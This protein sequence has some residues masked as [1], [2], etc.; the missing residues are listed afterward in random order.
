LIAAAVCG[1]G[2]GAWL[3]LRSRPPVYRTGEDHPEITRTLEREIPPE[4]PEPRFTEVG[5]EAGL[6]DYVPFR[7]E[8][9]SQLPEDMGPGAAWGDYDDD[10]DDDLFLVSAGG[11]LGAPPAARAPS[12]L[13]ENRGDGTF[14]RV[15]SFPDTRIVGMGAAWGDADGDGRLDL[16]VTGYNALIL[17]RNRGGRF[18]RDPAFPDRRGFWSGASWADFDRDGDLDLY[19]CGYVQYVEES[20]G[21][22]RTSQQYGYSVPFTLNPASYRPQ[23]NLL[24][25][26]EGAGRFTEVAAALG[27]DDPRGRSLSALWHDFDD[28]GWPDL[29]VAND[30]SDNVLYH[31]RKG[32]LVD[33]S[34]PAWVADYR[35]AMGLAAADYNRDGD[36]D[37]F[38]SHWIAQE[39]ALYDSLLADRR[40]PPIA[41]SPG[42]AH[43]ADPAGGPAPPS[44]AL[45]FMDLAD[46]RGV[47]Y[48][49][50]QFV[51]WGAEFADFD[52]DGWVD[53]AVANGSTFETQEAPK[54]LRSQE[55][56]LFWNR[57]GEHFHNLALLDTVLSQPRVGRGL[58]L[59]DYDGDGDVDI[60]IICRHDGALLLR[61]EMRRGNWAELRLR[62]RPRRAGASP[63]W[64]DGARVVAL[65]GGAA[66]RRTVSSASYL[67]QSSRWVHLG[68][69]EA[70][71]IER[72][73]VRWPGGEV[74][75]A[76]NLEAGALY[77]WL[78]GEPAPR[79]AGRQTA[80]AAPEP[81]VGAAPA[82]AP[83]PLTR[84]QVVEF[85]EKQR[86]AMNAMKVDGDIPRAVRLF[87]EALAIDPT[88]EDSRYY[89]GNCLAASGDLEAAL[90][91]FEEMT[92]LNP[93]SHRAFKR[94][95]TLRAIFAST[96]AHLEA[97][98][99]SLERAL[100]INPEETGALLVLGEI[101][102]VRGRLD[103]AE[104]RLAWA[105]R[106][107]P[108]AAGG[109]FL[110]GYVAWRRGEPALARGLL[111]KARQALG[112]E[113]TPKGA[114]SEGDVERRLHTDMTPLSRFW[115]EWDG[116]PDPDSAFRRLDAHLR[117]LSTPRA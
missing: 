66:L 16:V 59:S 82:V 12:L 69:G 102:L 22:T 75:V 39:N 46:A 7:G 18:E 95:G 53:L 113:W 105:C 29:Y 72:L 35:G 115:E 70:D 103:S 44:S 54:R 87:R 80:R 58:A 108:R 5:K 62:S 23:P 68:L 20:G 71:R 2:L 83:G 116:R 21:G 110:R 64:A 42:S 49:A 28:D 3:H 17:Y 19:V 30:I 1:V 65:A 107:N 37:L 81:P 14:R 8:R 13:Y 100:A 40:S 48:I 92:R 86:A 63:G 77:D 99:R 109:F 85:W 15:E 24:F 96:P 74:Q 36:D 32:K 52:A 88:H 73:E 89:L 31:N 11:P 55:P 47:G 112:E 90:A 26:N 111:E 50:L 114:T 33:V 41:S 61:N 38:V 4:A 60:L 25:R 10:G 93:Q 45:R 27:V 51:G 56:F 34:H 43:A 67:S 104:Q 117:G 97:A 9:T 101:D 57:R 6:G 91:Q 76:E 79:L 98:Q 94:W 78:E 84:R 106:T